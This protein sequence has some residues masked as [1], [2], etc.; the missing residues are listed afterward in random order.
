MEIEKDYRIELRVGEYRY[1]AEQRDGGYF[2]DF[3]QMNGQKCKLMMRCIMRYDFGFG[4]T[5]FTNL[6]NEI[7]EIGKD[8]LLYTAFAKFLDDEKDVKILSDFEPDTYMIISKGNDSVSLNVKANDQFEKI[9]EVKNILSDARS[10]ASNETKR[11][12]RTLFDDMLTIIECE[13]SKINND[14]E[15]ADKTSNREIE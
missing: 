5:N 11:K 7:F 3:A 13:N 6:D 8:C 4:L 12:L 14:I 1:I 9:V 15:I 10:Y 2:V